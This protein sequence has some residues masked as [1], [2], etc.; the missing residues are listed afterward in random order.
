M[1]YK[2]LDC[3]NIFDE[4]EEARWTENMGEY[5]GT[6]CLESMTGCPL[7]RGDYDETI[8]CEIC[9]SEHLENE[10]NNGICEE[11]IESFKTDID[12]CYE[13]GQN[14]IRD[15]KLNG[16]L[17]TIFEQA[18]IEEILFKFLKEREKIEKVDCSEYINEDEIWFIEEVKKN[19][20]KKK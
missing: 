3:G 4:G 13:V 9:G 1:S 18:A 8:P 20:C 2:C 10:L 17:S 19:E 16:F 11:C 5:W 15:I 14:D 12:I 7:C 6:P